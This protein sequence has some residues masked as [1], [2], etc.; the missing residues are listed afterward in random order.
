MDTSAVGGLKPVTLWLQNVSKQMHKSAKKHRNGGFPLDAFDILR[1]DIKY[2]LF[3]W[4]AAHV[5][6]F[7][8]N[9]PYMLM[10]SSEIIER[11]Y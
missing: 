1:V 7:F 3:A 6:N 8:L 9:Y 10:H 5:Q 4:K 11:K 2:S